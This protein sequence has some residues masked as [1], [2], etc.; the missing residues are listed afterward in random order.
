M[1]RGG[2]KS[3]SDG[4]SLDDW[5]QKLLVA[6]E[7]HKRSALLARSTWLSRNCPRRTKTQL[8]L[9]AIGGCGMKEWPA[10][11]DNVRLLCIWSACRVGPTNPMN[12][13][14][15]PNLTKQLTLP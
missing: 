7:L 8:M 2:S 5:A 4:W 15:T 10:P 11:M 1:I 3:P 6:P 12:A 13:F 9:A 14:F